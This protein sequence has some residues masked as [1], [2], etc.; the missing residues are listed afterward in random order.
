MQTAEGEH[1]LNS[2]P[3]FRDNV[4]NIILYRQGIIAV[5]SEGQCGAEAALPS[6]RPG[7]GQL[8]FL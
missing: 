7:M 4:T 5:N 6:Q 1:K 2:D 8:P 3:L